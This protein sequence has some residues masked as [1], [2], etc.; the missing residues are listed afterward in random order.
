MN[1]K[2]IIKEKEIDYQELAYIILASGLSHPEFKRR[3]SGSRLEL[4]GM[5]KAAVHM[6]VC[7]GR[8]GGLSL[9]RD[10]CLPLPPLPFL[11]PSLS[12]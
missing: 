7:V 11:S 2:I 8:G 4:T 12:P 10:F 1:N 9:F 6:C 3:P 5:A